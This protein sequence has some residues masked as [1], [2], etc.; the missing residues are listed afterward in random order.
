MVQYFGGYATA[1][2]FVCVISAHLI[3][4]LRKRKMEKLKAALW[5][6][7]EEQ[8]GGFPLTIDTVDDGSR[9]FTYI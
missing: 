8:D 5:S 2:G 4:M 7:A 9:K 1:F 3:P 6:Y